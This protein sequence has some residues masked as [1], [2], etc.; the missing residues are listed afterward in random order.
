MPPGG[1]VK[2][3]LGTYVTSY[4]G[5]LSLVIPPWVG[6]VSAVLGRTMWAGP[7]AGAES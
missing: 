3:H 1:W 4:P 5:Q 2:F 7:Y 6:T